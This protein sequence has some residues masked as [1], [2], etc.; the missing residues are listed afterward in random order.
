M[1]EQLVSS[2]LARE[3]DFTVV[4]QPGGSADLAAV[5]ESSGAEV[6]ILGSPGREIPDAVGRLLQVHPLLR[7]FTLT[8]DGKDAF[9]VE[10][11]PHSVPIQ[12]VSFPR[13]VDEIRS[14]LGARPQRRPA[15]TST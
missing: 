10:L 3:D 5:A 8:P 1:L 6:I 4:E 12:G 7:V 14:A 11:R 9:R 2:T 15:E 13:L